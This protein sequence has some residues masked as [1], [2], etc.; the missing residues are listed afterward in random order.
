MTKNWMSQVHK[1]I[2]KQLDSYEKKKYTLTE[3]DIERIMPK[4][5]EF[6]NDQHDDVDVFK[7]ANGVI[8]LIQTPKAIHNK[9]GDLIN[10]PEP[11]ESTF[12]GGGTQ[13]LIQNCKFQLFGKPESIS[14]FASDEEWQKIEGVYDKKA[15]IKAS[16]ITRKLKKIGSDD[17]P[18]YESLFLKKY[19][20]E[21]LSDID[22]SEYI[23]YYSVNISQ[24]I[25]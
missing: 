21:D 15:F 18:M 24:V 3:E 23:V 17:K 10:K 9:D 8:L 12:E 14:I 4:V 19:D 5:V 25:V 7:D 16:K 6:Y 13:Y 1:E 11:Y 22:D 2:T 20:L